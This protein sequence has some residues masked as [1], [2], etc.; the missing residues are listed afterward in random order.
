[1]SGK[2]LLAPDTNLLAYETGRRLL[3][4]I[5]IEVGYELAVLPEVYVEVRR[6]MSRI[7]ESRWIDRLD[8]DPRFED[9][10]KQRIVEAAADGAGA[11]FDAE[12]AAP[13]N[14]YLPLKETLSQ[15]WQARRIAHNLPLGLVRNDLSSIEGDPLIL[16][17]AVIFGVALLSTNNLRT[18]DHNAV[19]EWA[20]GQI[21]RN[22]R[23]VYSPDETLE[24]LSEESRE[25]RY[26]WTIAYGMRP[27]GGDE[28]VC[29]SEYEGCLDRLYGA[30]FQ[31]TVGEARWEYET[32][33]AFMGTLSAAL[34][35]EGVEAATRSETRLAQGARDGA[36]RAGW[37]LR[38]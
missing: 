9:T 10:A 6:R 33:A 28:A 13:D 16:A 1:M 7:E 21:G 22:K 3:H 31:R 15:G 12:L 29:R 18:I 14:A 8:R 38:R 5:S 36:A 25:T 34:E 35:R 19:N 2:P 4:G 20:S 11:A 23:L 24:E 26:R 30:G 27:S 32:D 17:Q 37:S